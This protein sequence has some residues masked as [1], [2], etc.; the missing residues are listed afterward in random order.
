ML[1]LVVLL[2]LLAVAQGLVVNTPNN[3]NNG[4]TPIPASS[5]S[6]TPDVHNNTNA[7][8]PN[9]SPPLNHTEPSPSPIVQSRP[10]TTSTLILST[11]SPL[12]G[13][14]PAPDSTFQTT[15]TGPINIL[16]LPYLQNPQ[17]IAYQKTFDTTPPINISHTILPDDVSD[18]TYV[19]KIQKDCEEKRGDYDVVVLNTPLAG[20]LGD[21]F[22]D[23]SGWDKKNPD[24]FVDRIGWMNTVDGRLVTLPISS[25]Y[26]VM[27]YN[28]D[29]LDASGQDYPPMSI[30]EF[31][32]TAS[33]AITYLRQN[34]ISGVTGL[35][36][37]LSGESLTISTAEWFYGQNRNALI[38]IDG[39]VKIATNPAASILERVA[40]WSDQGILDLAEL[41]TPEETS[42]EESIQKFLSGKAIFMRHWTSTI[43]RIEKEKV[44][45]KWGVGP[46][47][48]SR[49]GQGVGA[50]GGVSVG[51]YRYTK[52]P[53][54]A[55][56]VAFW[57]SSVEYQKTLLTKYKL[58]FVPTRSQLLLDSQ[59]CEILTI[60]YC[61]LFA[62]TTPSLRPTGFAGKSY[63]NVTGMIQKSITKILTGGTTIKSSLESL[64]VQVR[65]EL[66]IALANST[67]ND[68][69]ST[70]LVP[71]KKAPTHVE[72][73]LSGLVMVIMVTTTV[74]VLLRQRF[75]PAAS[76]N[77]GDGNGQFQKLDDK[78][79]FVEKG[80][81][82]E[83]KEVK[84]EE[85]PKGKKPGVNTT[86]V[87]EA[88]TPGIESVTDLGGD[89]S[90]RA[91]FI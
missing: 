7:T 59:V 17:A 80:D 25:D 66:N 45:F 10:S 64:D 53:S 71:Q 33:A 21:C 19:D 22:L 35:T 30:D 54:A 26:G 34:E 8:T 83:M 49:R 23:L 86:F 43:P 40:T 6:T 2:S 41:S 12:P 74:V 14:Y 18:E 55:A 44:P 61:Q 79:N 9:P 27:F 50:L 68:P 89:K 37:Q 72:I 77:V 62:L 24:G 32:D 88:S 38:D 11:P 4:T 78:D 82:G 70:V 48:G 87:L 28:Q 31:E 76:K 16:T 13:G 75:K 73:Q 15:S 67:I 39:T 29:I 63:K 90:E 84:K 3:S 56:K 36:T 57:L 46:I 20:R 5:N 60:D 52:N 42:D 65:T 47:G 58:F 91:T 51:V 69:G 81:A 1:K 85:K